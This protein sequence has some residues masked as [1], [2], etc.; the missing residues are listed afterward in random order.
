MEDFACSVTLVPCPCCRTGKDIPVLPLAACVTLGKGLS[1][2][3]PTKWG[4][5]CLPRSVLGRT[6]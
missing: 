1:P 3:D 4:W 5:L 2:L 6:Q